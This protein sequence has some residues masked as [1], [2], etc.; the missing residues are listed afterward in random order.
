MG[1]PLK[2][3]IYLISLPIIVGGFYM[4]LSSSNYEYE[5]LNYKKVF[6]G[7]VLIIAGLA[8][9]ITDILI[10]LKKKN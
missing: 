1:I 7:I 5:F 10:M 2:L 4:I 9:P 8:Y 3:L 6:S